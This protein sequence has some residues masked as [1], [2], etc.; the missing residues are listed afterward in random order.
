MLDDLIASM[1]D[2]ELRYIAGRDYGC[3]LDAHLTALRRVLFD[4]RGEFAAGDNGYPYEVVELCAHHLE[5]GHE[6]E[7]ALCTLLVIRA[8]ATGFDRSTSLELK[9]D[10][11]ADSYQALPPPLRDAI[12]AALME[13]ELEGDVPLSR[14][15]PES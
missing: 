5:Q 11:Q 13:V 1:T 3:E 12:L 15:D 6:R 7:F 2:A 10:A 8:A 9:F 4:Q 14:W